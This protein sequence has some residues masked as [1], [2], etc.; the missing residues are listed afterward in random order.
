MYTIRR[1]HEVEIH[2][3]FIGKY[4]KDAYE[5]VDDYA[6][7][8]CGELN[9]ECRRTGKGPAWNAYLVL[10]TEYRVDVE[11]AAKKIVGYIKKFKGHVFY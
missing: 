5:M 4:N 2:Y 6:F 1:I 9:V 3:N 10:T 8:I 7:K 11:K